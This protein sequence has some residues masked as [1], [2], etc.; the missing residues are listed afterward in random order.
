MVLNNLGINDNLYMPP[1]SLDTIFPSS[2]LK[3]E[4]GKWEEDLLKDQHN[5]YSEAQLYT[6]ESPPNTITPSDFLKNL[7]TVVESDNP[8]EC[9]KWKGKMLPEPFCLNIQTGES[10]DRDIV[11]LLLANVQEELDKGFGIIEINMKENSVLTSDLLPE[12][13]DIW[14]ESDKNTF[15]F[16]ERANQVSDNSSLHFVGN[17]HGN[18][19]R[20]YKI[21]QPILEKVRQN[22][23]KLQGRENRFSMD[24]MMIAYQWRTTCKGRWARLRDNYRKSLNL[25]KTK[26][27]Q[28]ACK[29][30]APKFNK[31][32]RFLIP[33]LNDEENRVSNISGS[34]TEDDNILS[35]IRD[36]VRNINEPSPSPP[37]PNKCYTPVYSPDNNTQTTSSD[38]STSR[39]TSSYKK[40]STNYE[41]AASVLKQYVIERK[42]KHNY[43]LYS[44]PEFRPGSAYRFLFDNGQNCQNISDSRASQNKI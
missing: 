21:R 33:Y 3:E 1:V 25:R 8:S 10:M 7:K 34:D 20:N 24:E 36:N 23:L 39:G 32:L 4:M 35:A 42:T 28:A 14:R 26:S 41:T 17:N 22:Y 30:K 12:I 44:M 40:R 38:R 9:I 18:G 15:S 2:W 37:I 19:G 29:I 31:E 13:L 16:M 5:T 27:G 11:T 43:E 6:K